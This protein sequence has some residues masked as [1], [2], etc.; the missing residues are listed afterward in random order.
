MAGRFPR[1]GTAALILSLAASATGCTSAPALQIAGTIAGVAM[2]AAGL[3]KTEDHPDPDAPQPLAMTLS[4]GPATNATAGGE[5]LA[6]VVRIYQL[7]SDTAFARLTY[8]QA[9]DPD[10]ERDALQN[11][12]VTV[13]EMTLLPGRIYRFEEQVPGRVKVIGVVAQFHKPAA[14]RWK[15][16]FD[17]DASQKAG[18]AIG[19]H[20]CAMTAGTGELSGSAMTVSSRSLSGVRCI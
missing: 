11:D 15:L 9:S 18:I 17:R 8:G 20:A 16:A 7:R 6:L 1:F 12:L 3:R 5:P 14:N 13:R 2:E 19:F 4:T 10:A